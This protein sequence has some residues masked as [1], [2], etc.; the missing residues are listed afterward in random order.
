[1]YAATDQQRHDQRAEVFRPPQAHFFLPV[2]RLFFVLFGLGDDVD[3]TV[4]DLQVGLGEVLAHNAGAE[5]LDAAAQQNDADHA[6]P[7][8]GRV[9]EHQRADDDK[10]DADEREDAEQHARPC[11]DQQ[12]RGGEAD[13]ALDGVLEQAPEIPLG[14]TGDA[15]DVLIVE[16]LGLEADPAEN[17]CTSGESKSLYLQCV[18]K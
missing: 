14:R 12:R 18:H 13:D 2:H 1:M 3:G 4:L 7:A 10:E 15:L 11:R 8:G 9:A 17:A 5:Q 6:G 16:P